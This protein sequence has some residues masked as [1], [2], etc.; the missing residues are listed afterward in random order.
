MQIGETVRTSIHMI[1]IQNKE[2]HFFFDQDNLPTV[3]I[4]EKKYSSFFS[5]LTDLPDLQ[6]ICDLDK[7]AQIINFFSK[8]LEFHY[9]E[10][11]EHFKEDYLQRIEAE[12]IDL[13]GNLHL[14]DYGVFNVGL[15]HPPLL[16]ER[17]LIFF[18]KHDYNSLP[19]RVSFPFPV[20]DGL[21]TIRYEL[22]PYL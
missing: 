10:N 21:V 15:L 20:T 9:I 1:S 11:I 8:G 7:V 18:V 4:E 19:Y 22:L 13:G 6:H 16:T 3:E 5:L 12:Q 14:S 2:L 17:K